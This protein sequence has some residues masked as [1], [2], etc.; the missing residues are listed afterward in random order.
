MTDKTI[1]VIDVDNTVA[2]NSHRHSF[3]QAKD[4]D[5]FFMD[6]LVEKDKPINTKGHFYQGHFIH[7]DHMFLTARPMRNYV[8]TQ[9][10]LVRHGYA[11]PTTRLICK[12]EEAR[13]LKAPE[14]KL[15]VMQTLAV[16]FP[17]Y[18]FRLIDDHP[19]T[20]ELVPG[21][22][23]APDCWGDKLALEGA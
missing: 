7:G 22:V 15:G 9:K 5:G 11:T 23:K 16:D 12:P 14:F 21:S 17:G 8:V 18:A 19:R 1:W 2:D 3:A 20:L 13:L 10:W 4:W 6:A